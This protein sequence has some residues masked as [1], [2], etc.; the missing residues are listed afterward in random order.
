MRPAQTERLATKKAEDGEAR[1]HCDREHHKE[2]GVISA[3]VVTTFEDT[4]FMVTWPQSG[5]ATMYY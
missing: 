4:S 1:L 3:K 5:F 2:P